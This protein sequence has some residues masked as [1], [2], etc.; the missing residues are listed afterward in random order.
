MTRPDDGEYPVD[1]VARAWHVKMRGD[2]ADAVRD[3]F[4]AWRLVSAEHREAYARITRQLAASAILKT[5]ARH[6]T[7]RSA[8]R[9]R[10]FPAWTSWGAATAAA[11]FLVAI[12]AGGLSLPGMQPAG[13]SAARAAEPLVTKRGEIR[14]FRVGDG[15][16]IT[17]DTDS[18]V[19][20]TLRN[21]AH[22]L[23]LIKGRARLAVS[24]QA[25][26]MRVEAGSAVMTV[27]AGEIDIGVDPAGAV[28][29]AL[30]NGTA[31][32]RANAEEAT[33]LTPGKTFAVRSSSGRQ[34]DAAAVDPMPRDWPE[35][36]AEYQTI[37]LDRLVAEANRYAAVPIVIDDKSSA[38]VELS[39][40]FHISDTRAFAERVGQLLDLSVET[41][42]ASI[43]L[44]RR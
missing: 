39:G 16:R 20:V 35:G 9:R 44:H 41:R 29:V 30:R 7:A 22:M 32:L 3:E 40:R 23:R 27:T 14:T 1:E 18:R 8:G 28:T 13:S 26:P 24:G 36:W 6:G 10:Q 31:S 42:T 34:A 2:D 19:D 43:H 4:E 38:A 11:L 12:G 17:L 21:G 33:A 25:V 15:S 37:R 5:S